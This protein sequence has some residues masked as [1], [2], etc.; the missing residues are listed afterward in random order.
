MAKKETPKDKK[1]KTLILD[2][3]PGDINRQLA[4]IKSLK[5]HGDHTV[6]IPFLDVLL[7]EDDDRIQIEIVDAL[8]TVKLSAVP[9]IIAKALVEEKYAPLRQILLSSVWNSGLDY[10]PYI[11]DIIT[12]TIQGDLLEAIECITI[13]ENIEGELTEEQIMDA[14]L[15]LN[16]YLASNM[17]DNSQRMDL[18][19]EIALLLQERYDIL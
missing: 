2:L 13:I 8:N 3:R 17:S 15:V 10:K 14:Q 6:V 18:L 4:A 7:N 5:V 9:A 12:A 11:K 19:R 16:E 1:I